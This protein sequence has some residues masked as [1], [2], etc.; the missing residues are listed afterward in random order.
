MAV[1]VITGANRGVGLGLTKTY[2]ARGDHVIACVRQ[3]SKELEA[4]GAEVHTGVD[5]RDRAAIIDFSSSIP[6]DTIDLIVNNAAIFVDRG[7]VEDTDIEVIEEELR[8]NVL[9]PLLLTRDLLN[10]LRDGGKIAF[11]SSAIGSIEENELGLYY[12][13]RMSKAS[14]NMIVKNLSNDLWSRKISTI[15]IHPGFVRTRLT[16]FAGEWSIEE[17]AEGMVKQIDRLTL[18]TSGTFWHQNG[19]QIAW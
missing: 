14:I 16:D 19:R 1:V 9:G 4:T 13:Y 11:V 18:D 15:A 12:G 7:P 17:A 10:A 3:T 8:V 2:S 5:L 6:A